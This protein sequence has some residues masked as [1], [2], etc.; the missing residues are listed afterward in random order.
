MKKTTP[1]KPLE[2][3]DAL[4]TACRDFVLD[5][6]PKGLEGNIGSGGDTYSD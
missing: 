2:W 5:I 1:L 3:S 6:G 4:G